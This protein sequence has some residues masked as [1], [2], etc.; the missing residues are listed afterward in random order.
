MT[1]TISGSFHI[2]Y[3][4]TVLQE[5]PLNLVMKAIRSIKWLEGYECIFNKKGH[6]FRGRCAR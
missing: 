4:E 5:M 2:S 3:L 6:Q 1:M